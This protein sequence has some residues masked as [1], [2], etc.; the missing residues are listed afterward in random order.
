M[1]IT[2]GKD[3]DGHA[4]V[5]LTGDIRAPIRSVWE[6]MADTQRL[7]HD[8]YKMP[9]V[10]VV[11]HRD[12][13]T[14]VKARAAGFE[15]V[16]EEQPWLYEAPSR[17]KSVRVFK[18]GPIEM[19]QSVCELE[20]TTS[21]TRMKYTVTLATRGGPVGWAASK[22][23][24]QQTESGF[25]KVREALL[26]LDEGRAPL[27]YTNPDRA[28]V[29]K[30]ADACRAALAARA[31]HA[32]LVVEGLLEHVAARP[33]DEVARMRPYALAEQW[34]LPKESVLA[35][36]LDAVGAG[37]LQMRWETLCPSCQG[38]IHDATLLAQVPEHH[39]C[40]ACKLDVVTNPASNVAAV[41]QPMFTIRRSKNATYCLGSPQRTPHWIA[42]LFLEAGEQRTFETNL[43][44]GRYLLQA[45]G[46]KG[47]SILD[48]G[49]AGASEVSVTIES[50]SVSGGAIVPPATPI[51]RAGKVAVAIKNDDE[52]P[53]RVQ[54]VHEGF[55]DLSATAAHV[56]ET[57]AWKRLQPG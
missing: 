53:R 55:A 54:L 45:T 21:G 33:D 23:F 1:N 56:I 6:L 15:M 9:A 51:V 31:E 27:L 7:N 4:V 16:F 41:F 37:L 8:I 18:K 20:E 10:T 29:R 52:H 2:T 44:T 17:Y 42:Q 49:A 12:D 13:A 38:P 25:T 47:R 39:T 35:V 5:E 30:R 46:M 24:G 48:V 14:V 28:G 3:A 57:A 40:G 22:V 11:E 43:D 19:L 36:C 32:E 34:K 26:E 50:L